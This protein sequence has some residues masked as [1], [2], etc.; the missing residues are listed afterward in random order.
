MLL[1]HKN[2]VLMHATT[3]MNLE[4]IKRNKLDTKSQM[5]CDPTYMKNLD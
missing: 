5:L 1:S 2:E 4:N 3:W